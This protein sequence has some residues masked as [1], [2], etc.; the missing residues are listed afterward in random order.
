MTTDKIDARAELARM[1]AEELAA[2]QAAAKLAET[3]AAKRAA[4]LAQ[5][6]EEDLKEVRAKCALHGFSQ[7]EL[8]GVLKKRAAN[9]KTGTEPRKS[10]AARKTAA[11]TAA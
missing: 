3:N 8:R 7:G 10:R 1:D 9:K 2:Q 11:K 5:T 6:R 4:L